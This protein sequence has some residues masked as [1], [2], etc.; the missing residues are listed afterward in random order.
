MIFN[1]PVLSF[2]WPNVFHVPAMF[3]VCLY[4]SLFATSYA[5]HEAAEYES[6]GISILISDNLK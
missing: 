5:I 4:G 3:H 1:T 2:E 6:S